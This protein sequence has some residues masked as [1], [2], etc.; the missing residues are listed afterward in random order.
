[1]GIPLVSICI[2]TYNGEKYIAE[3]MDS[4]IAQTYDNLENIVS[5]DGYKNEVYITEKLP[6]IK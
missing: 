3:A 2:P 6:K 1:M 4:A 5:E